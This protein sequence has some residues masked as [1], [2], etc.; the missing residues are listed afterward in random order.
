MLLGH[1][2]L[3]VLANFLLAE[4]KSS[5]V[6]ALIL[7]RYLIINSLLFIKMDE[8]TANTFFE[9][10][11][12]DYDTIA[13][14][15]SEVRE[16]D[17]EEMNFLFDNYLNPGDR[18]LDLGC[19]NGRFYNNFHPED[20]EYVGL[21]PSQKLINIA[22]ENHPDANFGVANGFAIPYDDEYFDKVF[23]I[24]VL[25]HIPSFAFRQYFLAE[26][27]RALKVGG[28]LILTVWDMSEKLVKRKF[29]PLAFLWQV[30]LEKGDVLLPWYGLKDVY[31]HA[32]TLRELSYLAQTMG[33]RVVEGGEIAVGEKPYNNFYIV[34][35]RIF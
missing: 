1:D 7:K 6:S 29:N 31:F 11:I 5:E 25:H 19:G 10:T 22:K 13:E 9:K 33:L 12:Q 23:S 28:Y 15:Y 8:S 4:D 21:D 34:T 17:W 26:A 24:A 2:V 16:K 32:F 27:M 14:K 18:V 20:V 35:Q 3:A 30:G